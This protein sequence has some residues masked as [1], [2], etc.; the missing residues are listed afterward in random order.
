[1]KVV[2]MS[3]ERT[4]CMVISSCGCDVGVSILIGDGEASYNFVD[5][6]SITS[7]AGW[8]G[9]RDN[10]AS[11]QTSCQSWESSRP[12]MVVIWAKIKAC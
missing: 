10:F 7:N 11:S 9:G 3:E 2:G 8:S 1:M 6:K 12:L 4:T 5:E